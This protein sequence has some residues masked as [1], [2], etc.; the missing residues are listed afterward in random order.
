MVSWKIPARGQLPPITFYWH[1]G[2]RRPGMRE[3]LESLLG[4]GLDWGD[5]GAKKW[6]D[7]AGCL[8]IGSEGKLLAT[9]HN[10]TF[11]L[12]PEAKFEDVQTSKPETVERSHGH[13]RDWLLA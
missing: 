12:L 9:A 4:R 7:W 1:N 8:F 6:V 10:A 11:T 13:Q 5:K 2:S 3:K